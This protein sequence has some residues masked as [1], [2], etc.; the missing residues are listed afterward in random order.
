MRLLACEVVC[1]T[2][3]WTYVCVLVCIGEEALGGNNG[4]PPGVRQLPTS[5][6]KSLRELDKEALMGDHAW[7]LAVDG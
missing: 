2:S 7:S 4:S 6:D 5:C 1:D 3:T